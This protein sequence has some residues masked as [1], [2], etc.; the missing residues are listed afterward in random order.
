MASGLSNRQ[1]LPIVALLAGALLLTAGC[2]ANDP[3]TSTSPRS[4]RATSSPEPAGDAA[5]VDPEPGETQ[6]SVSVPD[7]S[8]GKPAPDSDTP[9]ADNPAAA[10]GGHAASDPYGDKPAVDPVAENGRIFVDWPQP[11][12]ALLISGEQ[13][14]Y[15]EPC[16]CAGLENQKGGLKR[17]HSLIKQLDEQGWPVVSVDLGDQIKRFGPQA[18]IKFRKAVESLSQIGYTGVGFGP[19]DLRLPVEHLIGTA[20]NLGGESP[21]FVSAN[22]GLF[23]L[24][25]EFVAPFKV[26][27]AGGRRI[28]ITSILGPSHLGAIN[29]DGIQIIPAEEGLQKAL[30]E[31][32]QQA[33]FL[34]LLSHATP[35]ESRELAAKFPEFDIVV[36]AGGAAEPPREPTMLDGGKTRLVEIGHKGMYV[37]V[38]GLYDDPQTP[39]RYQRVPLDARFP[40][41]PAMQQ[42]LVE[43]QQ[44]LKEIGLG[45]LVPLDTP[46][47]S[48]RKFVGSAT[49][50]E[51]HTMAGDTWKNTPHAHATE[52][53]T[54]LDPPRQFDP[55]CISC[56]AT[57]WE[58]QKYIPF[59]SGFR[60]LSQTPHLVTNGCENCHGPGSDHVAAQMGDV[61][62][63][64][65]RMKELQEQM[66]VT[67]AEAEAKCLECHDLDNSPDFNFETYWPEVEH[68]GK[69]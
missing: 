66:R 30:P 52:T 27:E 19:H 12:V 23:E 46:H 58:P 51:C 28:G 65:A 14:G 17:R 63:D 6:Q 18:N 9:L 44:E 41:S 67:L 62:V 40:D 29:N 47:P 8:H 7:A 56:H 38:L 10:D 48:G 32:R 55:E 69:E 61:D 49:C 33:D 50:L 60:D 5:T 20:A 45:G 34:V 22:V 25:S 57:G 13:Q 31:L 11:Q 26:V 35:A 53:L 43:Y 1:A 59:A 37:A 21:L 3:S 36:T 16:G 68:H 2:P 24:P 64:D 4:E 42:M 54:K 15:L 39:I